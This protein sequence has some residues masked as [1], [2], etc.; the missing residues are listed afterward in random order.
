MSTCSPT[1][2]HRCT[3]RRTTPL[4]ACP[5]STACE[6]LAIVLVRA[7]HV[8]P[9][10]APGGLLGVDIFLV[11]S[12]YLITILL[13]EEHPRTGRIALRHFWMRRA[14]RL[15]PAI[16]LAVT[17]SISIG[18]RA[19]NLTQTSPELCRNLWVP[20]GRGAV[21]PSLAA[22]PARAPRRP[23]TE[24]PHCHCECARARLRIRN[25]APHR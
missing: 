19:E 7:Y 4:S 6:P 18:A 11:V 5:V 9:G 21:L 12:R 22:R 23:S 3:P 15:L 24:H 2:H 16:V 17:V 14:R 20:R 8:F 25:G 1:P 10:L 13:V